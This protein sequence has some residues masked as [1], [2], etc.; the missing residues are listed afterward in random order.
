MSF[1]DGTDSSSTRL[2]VITA[3]VMLMVFAACATLAFFLSLKSPDQVMVPHVVGKDLPEALLELQAKELYPRLQLRYSANAEERGTVLEQS[4]A[5]GAIVKGGKRIELV[6]SQGTVIDTVQ[7]YVGEHIEAVQERIQQLFTASSRRYIHLRQ[8]FLTKYSNEPAGIIIEQHPPAGTPLSN[9]MELSFVVSK[10]REQETTKVPA[11]LKANLEKIYSV[12]QKSAL[13]F[14]FKESD[15]HAVS[16]LTV[17][18]QQFAAQT[19]VPVFSPV[20]V[21]V[22]LPQQED[23]MISGILKTTLPEYPYPFTLSFSASYQN[24]NKEQLAHFRHPGGIC[25]IPY[26]VPPNTVLTLR[27]LN[28]DV[29]SLTVTGQ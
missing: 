2:I 29:Y 14:I 8:P 19:D 11:L 21:Q 27:V 13:V 9:N 23:T 17:E 1:N 10:G 25:T 7:N 26:T 6:V 20:E 5:A 3:T 4:P 22:A 24:G 15:N 12:M 28:K 18:H 16:A